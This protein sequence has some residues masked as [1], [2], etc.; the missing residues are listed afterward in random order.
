MD[1][2]IN[3]DVD[4]LDRAI[5]F[6]TRVFE[7]TPGR[8]FGPAAVELL[9]ATSP[10]YLLRKPA[11]SI[12][13]RAAEQL[14]TYQRH[15]T[16]VHLDFVTSDIESAIRR[17]LDEGATLERPIAAQAWGQLALMADPFGNGFCFVQFVGDGYDAIVG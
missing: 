12:P 7:L 17:A 1:L 13:A 9:G 15:W 16:P 3:I 10:V 11:G 4:D 5:A 14:R 8:R 6:Y 2:L